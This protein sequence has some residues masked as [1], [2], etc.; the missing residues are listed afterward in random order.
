MKRKTVEEAAR[1]RLAWEVR[2]EVK[3]LAG[4]LAGV[5]PTELIYYDDGRIILPDSTVCV[6]PIAG[7]MDAWLAGRLQEY[8]ETEWAI[9]KLSG[10]V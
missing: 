10:G 3:C 1:V 7:A 8:V 2:F 5:H 9:S 6:I 4:K